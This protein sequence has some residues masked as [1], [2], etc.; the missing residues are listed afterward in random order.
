MSVNRKYSHNHLK[1]HLQAIIALLLLSTSCSGPEQATIQTA[2]VQ[3][4]Q[5]AIAEGKK[6]AA[7]EAVHLKE[8]AIAEVQTQAV[9]LKETAIAQIATELANQL[10]PTPQPTPLPLEEIFGAQAS[11]PSL[12]IDP[13]NPQHIIVG[14]N[15]LSGSLGGMCAW[16]ESRNGGIK[17]TKGV[18]QLPNRFK[19]DG[20]PWVRFGFNGELYY[21][22][23][24]ST[25]PTSEGILVT[26]EEI[27]VGIFVAA[28]P[29]GLANDLGIANTITTG[30][31]ACL[32]DN[33][34]TQSSCSELG[35][36]TDHPTISTLRR[37]DGQTRLIVCWVDWLK[38]TTENY[39]VQVASSAD[40]GNTWSLPITIAGY[41]VGSCTVGGGNDIIGVSWWDYRD[42]KI[43]LKTS[44][45]GENWS[46]A[47]E[48]KASEA[49]VADIST[50]DKVLSVPYAQLVSKSKGVLRAFYQV[51]ANGHSQVFV[52]DS[53]N[54]WQ[55]IRIGN[56]K[57]ETFL[58]G[59]STCS[60]TVGM[61]EGS[62]GANEDFT[63]TVWSV[64]ANRTVKQIFQSERLLYGINGYEDSRF[65]LRRIGDYTAVD[66]SDKLIWAAWTDTHDGE[67]RLW[68]AAILLP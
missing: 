68:G 37:K 59:T 16:A 27:T 10:P 66:C 13:S 53:D 46:R 61:Y 28:S 8:T 42:K 11:E 3:A 47:I 20:D 31:Q 15:D 9:Q 25:P 41:N 60:N 26:Y 18:L 6:V 67:P 43:K 51:R 4:G 55:G 34:S 40:G 22:C 64:S 36:Y 17:W 58:P 49:L 32:R 35:Q 29:T 63:Y 54:N 44:T 19:P 12:A 33:T 39:F 62:L 7:T 14:F 38:G 1:Y 50:T 23:I 65:S 2:I 24:G 45:D 57:S 48:L 56:Q 52:A 5:T 30:K 21:S